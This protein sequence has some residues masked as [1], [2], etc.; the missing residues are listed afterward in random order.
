MSFEIKMC[1]KTFKSVI[2]MIFFQDKIYFF[3][4]LTNFLGTL[5]SMI[6]CWGGLDCSIDFIYQK[7]SWR[8]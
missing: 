6:L 4:S 8:S 2:K 7:R 3:V 1:S 5:V